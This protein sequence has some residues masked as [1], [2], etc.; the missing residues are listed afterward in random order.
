VVNI[1]Q[2]FRP[3]SAL[4]DATPFRF[5]VYVTGSE[6]DARL[7]EIVRKVAGQPNTHIT[8]AYVV[9]VQQSIPLDAELPAEVV[10]GEQVLYEAGRIASSCVGGK[11]DHVSTE[12]LQARSAGAAIVDQAI[13]EEAD[14]I[15][16]AC[17]VRK[18]LGRSTVGD[19]V[20]YVLRNAPC[21]V[22]VIRC[23]LP[24]AHSE[25]DGS[26]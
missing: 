22:H 1:R 8:L 23:A 20:E 15:L 3:L 5:L 14:A 6:E 18:K 13:E 10:R 2:A 11:S 4:P 24:D 7:M 21:E 26:Q 9:E 16:L 19:T 25:G 17:S 12:L